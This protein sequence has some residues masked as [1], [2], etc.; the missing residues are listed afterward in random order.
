MTSSITNEERES[1]IINND[2]EINQK[3]SDK[4]INNNNRFNPRECI[5]NE[6]ELYNKD[7]FEKNE[8]ISVEKQFENKNDIDYN[9]DL[10]EWK[11]EEIINEKQQNIQTQLEQ[12]TS[13]DIEKSTKENQHQ[14]IGIEKKKNSKYIPAPSKE[15]VFYEVSKST[16]FPIE[17]QSIFNYLNKAKNIRDLE[18]ICWFIFYQFKKHYKMK[19]EGKTKYFICECCGKYLKVSYDNSLIFQPK[20]YS[21]HFDFQH[22]SN[23]YDSFKYC[24]KTQIA[25]GSSLIGDFNVSDTIAQISNSIF[26]EKSNEY[27]IE[28]IQQIFKED[29]SVFSYLNQLAYIN[30]E[31]VQFEVS[32]EMKDGK[33][34]LNELVI[35]FPVCDKMDLCCSLIGLDSTFNRKYNCV[36]TIATTLDQNR[37]ELCLGFSISFTENKAAA[38]LLLKKIKERIERIESFDLKRMIFFSDRGKAMIASINE[39]F[40][41]NKHFYCT[42]HI[43]KNLSEYIKKHLDINCSSIS[44]QMN[45]SL[46]IISTTAN[47]SIIA[48]EIQSIIYQVYSIGNDS[49]SLK[50]II[51]VILEYI[52]TKS[53][54]EKWIGIL[55]DD[56]FR[57]GYTTS[58]FQESFNH[59]ILESNK[60]KLLESIDYIVQKESKKITQRFIDIQSKK[61]FIPKMNQELTQKVNEFHSFENIN[62]KRIEVKD[63]FVDQKKEIKEFQLKSTNEQIKVQIHKLKNWKYYCECGYPQNVHIPC[64][65]LLYLM[66]YNYILND[67]QSFEEKIASVIDPSIDIEK[68]RMLYRNIGMSNPSSN[69]IEKGPLEYIPFDEKKPTKMKE[70]HKEKKQI[71]FHSF[72]LSM[73][74]GPSKIVSFEKDKLRYL[75][76]N[77]LERNCEYMNLNLKQMIEIEKCTKGQEEIFAEKK[78]ISEKEKESRMFKEMKT[79][80]DMK[81]FTNQQNEDVVID[82]KDFGYEKEEEDQCEIIGTR[83]CVNTNETKSQSNGVKRHRKHHFEIKSLEELIVKYRNNNNFEFYSLINYVDKS[84]GTIS[85]LTIK[86]YRSEGQIKSSEC[87]NTSIVS[88]ILELMRLSLE[89]K[90]TI[91][92][93]GVVESFSQLKDQSQLYQ[94][95]QKTKLIFIPQFEPGSNVGHYVLNVVNLKE[96]K[97][98]ILNSLESWKMDLSVRDALFKEFETVDYETN[99]QPKT[100]YQCGFRV[101]YNC[102]KV[103]RSYCKEGSMTFIHDNKEFNEFIKFVIDIHN[104]FIDVSETFF[105]RQ[106][107]EKHAFN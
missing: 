25:R 107:E 101:L 90:K 94:Y 44:S 85:N 70:I 89:R 36:K 48:S 28:V 77:Q 23:T 7:S 104:T 45:H 41:Q 27:D 9:N 72:K 93:F 14:S 99:Q 61:G 32:K 58:Q 92:I 71:H 83:K 84:I 66:K 75:L 65:H 5:S 22:A 39:V 2:N 81:R 13:M 103:L 59:S 49:K 54:P 67:Y 1:G 52:F 29:M 15:N 106:R 87:L 56:P 68:Y 19:T 8:S 26:G 69:T 98:Y 12:I 34:V 76:S 20:I 78:M 91:K 3:E 37:Q 55:M 50:E 96:K 21:Q 17:I 105:Q 53:D 95:N 35:T 31:A 64:E 86:N 73:R 30:E 42:W 57:Y 46:S 6:K 24:H 33:I 74:E 88:V 100:S 16:R 43:A 82:V 97:V 79:D 40:P 11:R 80:M 38:I 102:F 47:I 51:S 10:V 63:Y 62:G 60:I 18:D 4:L